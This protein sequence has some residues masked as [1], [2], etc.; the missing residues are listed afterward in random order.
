LQ[1]PLIRD[2]FNMA[3]FHVPGSL[4]TASKQ[5]LSE[6][7]AAHFARHMQTHSPGTDDG[8]Q[9][10][11]N[12]SL[13][14]VELKEEDIKKQELFQNQIVTGEISSGNW[15]VEEQHTNTVNKIEPSSNIFNELT[16][17]DLQILVETEDEISQA[18][19]YA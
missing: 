1:G 15:T 13:Y 3:R 8:S 19:G 4:N 9:Y 11:V 6:Y 18:K 2:V 7:V 17:N 14:D 10:C 5:Q 12:L 16:L